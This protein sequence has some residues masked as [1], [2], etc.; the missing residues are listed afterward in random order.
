MSS[1]QKMQ[2]FEFGPYR[3]TGAADATSARKALDEALA[4]VKDWNDKGFERSV[5][6][7]GTGRPISAPLSRS[8]GAM[9]PRR[10]SRV[11]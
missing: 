2:T 1:E 10:K 6:Q 9:G 5:K 3:V 7:P 8:K 11:S 4:G